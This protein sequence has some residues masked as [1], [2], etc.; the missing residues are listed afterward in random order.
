M[1]TLVLLNDECHTEFYV[2]IAWL[3]YISS[4]DLGDETRMLGRQ[5]NRVV[6]WKKTEIIGTFPLPM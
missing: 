4:R 5:G 3:A 1:H 6:G 2:P